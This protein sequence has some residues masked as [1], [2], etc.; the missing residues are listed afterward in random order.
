VRLFIAALLLAMLAI[1][2]SSTVSTARSGP[3]AADVPTDLSSAKKKPTKKKQ[4][5]KEE[6]LRAAPMAPSGQKM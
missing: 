1:P 5:P 2:G 6:Y 4:A 3:S